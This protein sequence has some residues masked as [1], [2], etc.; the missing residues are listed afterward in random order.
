MSSTEQRDPDQKIPKTGRTTKDFWSWAYSDLLTN[1]PRAVFA[2][3]LVGS[4]LDVVGG[5]R[6]SWGAYDLDY[7]NARIEVKS[8]SYIQGWA[9]KRETKPDFDIARKTA[10]ELQSDG[11]WVYDPVPRR[12]ADV[13]VFCLYAERD[14]K[15]A[16]AADIGSWEFYVLATPEIDERFGDQKK[17]RLSRIREIQ[18]PVGYDELRERVDEALS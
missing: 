7:A 12:R 11:A 9:Q 15:K 2:E 4:A 6:P 14:P 8:S 5:I 16:D 13:Y 10:D 1:I 18:V 3:W 17:I